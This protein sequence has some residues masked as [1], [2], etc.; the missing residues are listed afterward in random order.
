MQWVK[1]ANFYVEAGADTCTGF[2]WLDY[3]MDGGSV[4]LGASK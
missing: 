4:A 3:E 2:F 1:S